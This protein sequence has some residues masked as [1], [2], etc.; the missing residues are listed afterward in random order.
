MTK[1]NHAPALDSLPRIPQ[2]VSQLYEYEGFHGCACVCGLQHGRNHETGK[3]FVILT[4]LPG[5]TGTSVTNMVEVLAAQVLRRLGLD[6]ANAIIIEGE[7][8]DIRDVRRTET[9]VRVIA[10]RF[11]G[12]P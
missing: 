4:E 2:T 12:M 8:P 7:L 3:D 5:N 6:P 11:L 10:I 1:D 9:A